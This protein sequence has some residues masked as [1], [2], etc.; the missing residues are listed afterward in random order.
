MP[1]NSCNSHRVT[2]LLVEL[3]LS[4]HDVGLVDL[5]R[6]ILGTDLLEG[7]GDRLLPVAKDVHDVLGD[8]LGEPG[9][10]LLGFARPELHDDMWHCPSSQ[11]APHQGR[12]KV[13]IARRSS[14]ARYPSA[15]CSSGSVRSNTLPASTFRSSA[16]SMSRGR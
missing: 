1:R 4:I 13:L 5:L 6:P 15:T 9:F 12:S 3:R 11:I 14:I 8:F 2:R 10:L 16:S 7:H